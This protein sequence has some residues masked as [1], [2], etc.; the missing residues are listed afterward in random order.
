MQ[1]PSGSKTVKSNSQ[2]VV[3]LYM[4]ECMTLKSFN[5]PGVKMHQSR[6]NRFQNLDF[7][8]LGLSPNST[9]IF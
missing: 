2:V 6:M 4:K 3:E 5:D 7:L 8:P 9:N 1:F